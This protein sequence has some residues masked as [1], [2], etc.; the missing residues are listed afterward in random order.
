MIDETKM[1]YSHPAFDRSRVEE[2]YADASEDLPYFLDGAD[3]KRGQDS[4]IIES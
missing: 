3:N 2:R 1:Y 4:F